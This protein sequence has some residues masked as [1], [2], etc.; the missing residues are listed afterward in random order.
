MHALDALKFD[1]ADYTAKA[2]DINIQYVNDGSLQHTLLFKE[3]SGCKLNVNSRGD[4]KTGKV[5]LTAGTYTM[6]CDVPGHETGG[7]KAT[8]VVS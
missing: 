3:K 4:T 6:F 5:N 8:L 1:K 7:M 2:G